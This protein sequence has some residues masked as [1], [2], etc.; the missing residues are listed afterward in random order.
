MRFNLTDS[1]GEFTCKVS[2]TE[3]FQFKLGLK[4]VHIQLTQ[5]LLK[6]M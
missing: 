6:I 2:E 3:I 4:M 5:I 1:S